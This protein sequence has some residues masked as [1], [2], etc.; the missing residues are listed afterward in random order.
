MSVLKINSLKE[1]NAAAK[2]FLSIVGKK[3]VFALYGAMGVGKT[4][5]V[6]AICDEMGVED[7][8]N[9]PTFS[10]VNEYHTP[11][12]D[13]IYHFDFY[14]I[15]DVKEA[16]DFGY[17]DYFYGNAMCFIE[18]PEKIESILP[19]DTVEVFFKEE[20]DGSRSITIH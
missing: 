8:I 2:E 16:Y 13:I 17:E 3:R 10:I 18:W 9:S 5:F 11:K 20:M 19:N 6:K 7:T 15:E 12:D 14:R 1:I 4:T